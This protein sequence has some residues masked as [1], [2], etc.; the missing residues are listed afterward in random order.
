MP[1]KKFKPYVPTYVGE[2]IIDENGT[3]FPPL[4]LTFLRNLVVW[5]QQDEKFINYLVRITENAGWESEHE[6]SS[7]AHKVRNGVCRT[8][9]CVAGQAAVQIGKVLQYDDEERYDEERTAA[10]EEEKSYYD[11]YLDFYATYTEEGEN[12]EDVAQNAIGLNFDEAAALFNGDNDL[13]TI[14]TVAMEI[15]A[16]RGLSLYPLYDPEKVEV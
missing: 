12:I 14:E 15:C 10:P 4:D 3:E 11:Q 1:E 7:W 9:Y 2:H 8:A 13:E 5:C 6:Q 16:R